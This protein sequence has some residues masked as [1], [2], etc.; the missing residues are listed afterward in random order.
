MP[1]PGE[2]V[3]VNEQIAIEIAE[4]GCLRMV[5]LVRDRDYRRRLPPSPVS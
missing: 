5:V 2:T 4:D 3:R 1:S